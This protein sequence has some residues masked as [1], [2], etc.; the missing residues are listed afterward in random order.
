MQAQLSPSDSGQGQ[1]HS[2]GFAV[3]TMQGWWGA[4]GL[5]AAA[6]VTAALPCTSQGF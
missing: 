3:G 6:Y 5:D 4:G 2:R 1:W